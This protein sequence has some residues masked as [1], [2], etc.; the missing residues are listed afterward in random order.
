MGMQLAWTFPCPE[1]RRKISER[2][3]TTPGNQEAIVSCGNTKQPDF[4]IRVPSSHFDQMGKME[5]GGYAVLFMLKTLLLIMTVARYHSKETVC[6]CFDSSLS[7]FYSSSKQRRESLGSS[8]S[9]SIL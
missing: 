4:S 6:V 1:W 3:L 8:L 5:E 7:P 9:L 2:T